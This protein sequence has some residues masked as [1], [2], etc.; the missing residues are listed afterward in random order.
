MQSNN[1]IYSTNTFTHKYTHWNNSFDIQCSDGN[2]GFKVKIKMFDAN[3][4]EVD[5]VLF[6]KKG[7]VT[8]Q[9]F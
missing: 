3:P 6:I 2:S 5:A 9:T 7:K 1:L 8:S 4:N